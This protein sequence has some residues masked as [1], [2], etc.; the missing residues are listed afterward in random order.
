MKGK[1]SFTTEEIKLIKQLIDKKVVATKSEQKV[2][3]DKIRDIGFYFSSY[4]SKKGYTIVDLDEL[5]YLGKVVISD[6]N[7]TPSITVKAV[8]LTN[9]KTQVKIGGKDKDEV[10]VLDLCNE[11]L[12][13]KSLRQHK[14]EF[15]LGDTNRKG[16]AVRLP[17]DA[18]Y[19]TLKLVVEYR[20][21]Q[22]TEIVNF[23]DRPDRI[24]LSGVHRGEQRKLYDERRRTVLP[25]HGLELIEISFSDFNHDNQKRIIRDKKQDFQ[26]IRKLLGAYVDRM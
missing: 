18:Y 5:I 13:L 14:F 19:E 21:R 23:F 1:N 15:L 11:V 17:V 2:I 8:E 4:S 10:Y 7:Y 24:T 16:T 12:N 26:I 22:H 25:K 9:R 3:R 6:G 20:E